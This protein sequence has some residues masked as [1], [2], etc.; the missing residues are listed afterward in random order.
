VLAALVYINQ[1][2]YTIW[3]LQNADDSLKNKDYKNAIKLYEEGLAN[4]P[5][6][7]QKIANFEKAWIQKAF[8]LSAL[9]RYPDTL[10]AC[11]SAALVDPMSPHPY[12]CKGTALGEMGK[13]DLAIKS[14][15]RAIALNPNLY[16]AWQGRG[17]S[18]WQLTH[19]QNAIADFQKAIALGKDKAAVTW[20]DLGSLYLN[21]KNPTKAIEAYQ[22]AIN[23][24][25]KYL[26]PRI[27]LGNAFLARRKYQEALTVFRQALALDP[28]SYEAWYGKALV[29]ERLRQHQ[30][31]L[32]SYQQA[33]T[34]KP[35]SQVALAARQRVSRYVK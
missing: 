32:I 34:L 23:L 19:L 13:P 16:E 4:P 10:K 28:K 7:V 9:K 31:A 26:P 3:V 33:L 30:A 2:S 17:H 22:K 20:N 1:V 35:N 8:A 27:G 14:Y 5:P 6:F 18:Y 29:E 15:D 21:A 12:I 25:S 24:A 11:E